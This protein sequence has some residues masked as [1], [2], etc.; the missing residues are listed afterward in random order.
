MFEMPAILCDVL[1]QIEAAVIAFQFTVS[2]SVRGAF[3]GQEAYDLVTCNIKQV[4][5]QS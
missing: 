2:Y 3:T 5:L 4:I 1:S